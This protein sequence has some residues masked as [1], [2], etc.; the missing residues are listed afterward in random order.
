MIYV[1]HDQ[2]EAMTMADKI[3][4]L[5]GGR[6]EQIGARWTSTNNPA[7]SSSPVSSA[8]SEDET[9]RHVNPVNF[10]CSFK[11]CRSWFCAARL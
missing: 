6:I 9:R 5:K 1:T 10:M 11:P 3:V 2:V 4:V 8:V 7:N